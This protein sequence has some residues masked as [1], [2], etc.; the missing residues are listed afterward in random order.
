MVSFKMLGNQNSKGETMKSREMYET[1][2]EYLIENI[3]NHVSAGDVKVYAYWA[4]VNYRES[5]DMHVSNGILFNHES[6]RRAKRDWGF[7]RRLC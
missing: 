6:P 7:C 5:Y 3:G 2:Q 4:C 1:A